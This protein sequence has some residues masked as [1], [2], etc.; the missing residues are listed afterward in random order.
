MKNVDTIILL[1][2]AKEHNN[3]HF[4]PSQVHSQVGAWHPVLL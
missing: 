2:G 3:I 4:C 1:D